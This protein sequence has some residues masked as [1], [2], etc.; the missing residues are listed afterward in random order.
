MA[1][2]PVLRKLSFSGKDRV[3]VI[4]VDEVAVSQASIDAYPDLMDFGTVSCGSTITPTHW[5][6]ELARFVCGNPKLNTRLHLPVTGEH[7]AYRLRL[8]SCPSPDSGLVERNSDSQLQ[9][10][11]LRDARI[12]TTTKE[13][14]LVDWF[15]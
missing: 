13:I 1:T 3:V 2:N 10:T 4:H 15:P 12:K 8:T 5:F 7:K 6:P 11:V 9:D 14:N